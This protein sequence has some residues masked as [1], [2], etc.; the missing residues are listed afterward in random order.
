MHPVQDEHRRYAITKFNYKIADRALNVLGIM[1]YFA[2]GEKEMSD[3]E[4]VEL[5]KRYRRA[6]NC[7]DFNLA[8]EII[9]EAARSCS[10]S[11]VA[12]MLATI[13]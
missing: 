13:L 11:M 6:M 5:C 1:S 12:L 4:Y 2:K 10:V 7:Q 9:D 3:L 8:K